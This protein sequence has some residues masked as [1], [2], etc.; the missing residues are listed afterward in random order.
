MSTD[1]IIDI[2]T[3]AMIGTRLGLSLNIIKFIRI[4][5]MIISPPESLF[6][7]LCS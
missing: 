5:I 4:G 3:N 2:T 1:R 6:N 7:S